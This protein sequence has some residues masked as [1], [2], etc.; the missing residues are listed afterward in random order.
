MTFGI[1]PT[2]FNPKTLQ[3]VLASLRTRQRASIDPNWAADDESLEGQVNASHAAELAELWEEL[4]F[5]V[6]QFNPDDQEGVEQDMVC[7]ISGTTRL[8]ATKGTVTISL[9]SS[10]P[11]TW[12]AGTLVAQ[13]GDP[14]NVWVLDSNRVAPGA[15]TFNA[16]FTAQNTGHIEAPAGT[17]TVR[18]SSVPNWVGATNPFDANAGRNIETDDELRIRREEELRAEGGASEPAISADVEAVNP[19]ALKSVRTLENDGDI[20]DANGLPPHS[21][22]VL[23]WDP[24]PDGPVDNDL[25]AQAIWNSKAFGI[26][27]F[28]STTGTAKTSAGESKTMH[29]SRVNQD[30]LFVDIDIEIDSTFPLDGDAQVKAALKAVSESYL[31]GGTVYALDLRAASRSVQGVL[32]SPALRLKLSIPPGL[33]DTADIPISVRDIATLD[34]SNITVNHV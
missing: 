15:G 10:G 16:D 17:L 21:F 30:V 24:A 12:P 1:T 4:D 3:D 26:Q 7:A 13:D 32:T 31:P 2:G 14:T 5:V 29:F 11:T 8:S 27:T 6:N 25:I 33:G 18:L 20:V 19:T 28:G 9:Q 23:I 34:T 22:E